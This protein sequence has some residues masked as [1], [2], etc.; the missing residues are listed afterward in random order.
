MVDGV[1][2]IS[3]SLRWRTGHS[4]GFNTMT[5]HAPSLIIFFCSIPLQLKVYG[6]D[7][8]TRSGKF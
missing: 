3:Q 7:L 6:C 8:A 5:G 2:R 1:E 4:L